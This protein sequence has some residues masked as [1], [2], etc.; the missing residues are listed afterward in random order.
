M[1][2][3]LSA[4]IL[5][6]FSFSSCKKNNNGAT[7]NA[8]T[9]TATNST[10]F[11]IG[12]TITITGTHLSGTTSVTINGMNVIFTVINDSTIVATI[13]AGT[14]SGTICITTPDGTV[15]STTGVNIV[16]KL[17]AY[18]STFVNNGL[19]PKLYTCDSLGISPPIAWRDAPTGTNAYA[20][21]MHTIPP[22]GSNHVYMVV[23]NLPAN[24]TSVPENNTTV[25]TYG[26]NTFPN[27]VSYSPPCSQGPGLKYY[28]ITVYALSQQPTITVPQT[29]VTMDY[30]KAAISNITLDTSMITIG[31]ARP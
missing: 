5:F 26:A 31:Y 29:Q 15:T 2:Y 19:F 21:T 23:Y 20:I 25:G 7:S 30:L 14:T 28:Y 22:T 10:N 13:P 27:P 12:D 9:I 4:A 1:K 16:T 18:S 3:I 17:V 8:P 11:H 6:I 24:V